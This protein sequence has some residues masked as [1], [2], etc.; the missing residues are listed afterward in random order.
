MRYNSTIASSITRILKTPLGSRVM[1]P[2]YGSKLY[3]LRDAKYDDAFRLKAARYTYEA[4]SKNEPR[5]RVLKV[6]F[7]IWHERIFLLITLSNGEIIE[8]GND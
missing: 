2:E 8:V 7:K 3:E 6:D 4:I 5:V 1:R